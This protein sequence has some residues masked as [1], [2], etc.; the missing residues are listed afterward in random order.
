M[1][2][3]DGK[4]N[5]STP[6][7]SD[8]N[9]AFIQRLTIPTN[10]HFNHLVFTEIFLRGEKKVGERLLISLFSVF[11]TESHCAAQDSLELTILLPQLSKCWDS[12]HVPP[13]PALLTTF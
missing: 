5:T 12:R 13:C 3:K 2:T 4:D 10:S 11:E 6:R 7:H 1:P 8:S 9:Q